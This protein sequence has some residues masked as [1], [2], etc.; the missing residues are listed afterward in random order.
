MTV[1]G[2]DDHQWGG[3]KEAEVEQIYISFPLRHLL[4]LLRSFFA[5]NFQRRI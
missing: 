2:K 3:G 4:F 1:V 5:F